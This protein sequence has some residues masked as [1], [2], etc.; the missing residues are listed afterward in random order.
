MLSQ[1][2]HVLKYNSLLFFRTIFLSC[3]NR[4]DSSEVISLLK[5]IFSFF[6]YGH[7]RWYHFT[8][9]LSFMNNNLLAFRCNLDSFTWKKAKKQESDK[10]SWSFIGFPDC[11]LTRVLPSI[12]IDDIQLVRWQA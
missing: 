8:R 5:S 7:Q 1:T 10:E 9:I 6:K 4:E 3:F 11:T 2:P 12:I